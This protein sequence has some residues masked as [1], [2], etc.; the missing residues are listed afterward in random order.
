MKLSSLHSLRLPLEL[1]QAVMSSLKSGESFNAW[2]LSAAREKLKACCPTSQPVEDARRAL[3]VLQNF[4][5]DNGK[6]VAK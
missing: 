6:E 3:V 2:M 1:S 5:S 4:I